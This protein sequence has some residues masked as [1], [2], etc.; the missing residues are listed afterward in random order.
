MDVVSQAQPFVNVVAKNE[1]S[2][3][4]DIIS[5]AQPFVAAYDNRLNGPIISVSANHTDVQSWLDNVSWNGGSASAGTISALNTFCAAIDNAGIRNKFYRL[6]L[7]CGNNLASCLVPLYV[8]TST[9][10]IG[11]SQQ[12]Y[13]FWSDMNYGF[14][15]SDYNETGVSGGLTPNNTSN[16][17]LDTGLKQ[18]DLGI[19]SCH[20][21]VYECTKVTGSYKTRIGS[22]GSSANNEHMLTNATT[23]IMYYGCSSVGGNHR[24]AA[25]SYTE[26]GAFWIGINTSDTSSTI[27]KNSTQQG[28][29]TPSTRTPQNLNYFVF[30]LNDNGSTSDTMITGRLASYSI[31][32]SMNSAQVTS[33]YNAVQAFQTSLS[34]NV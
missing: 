20:L 21:S 23:D 11:S 30:A 33:Y 13:G 27:Y 34:R 29:A 19:N 1:N 32:L 17:R 9:M 4:L 16:K 7:F 2:L 12:P 31:G 6:N 22:R 5:N 26:T 28:T 3:G 8:S 25:T 15:S 10:Q 24:A 18:T 14:L